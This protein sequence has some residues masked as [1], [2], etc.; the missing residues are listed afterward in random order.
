MIMR[1]P[2]LQ[3]HICIDCGSLLNQA[4]SNSRQPIFNSHY[5]FS[6]IFEHSLFL[7][8]VHINSTSDDG[9]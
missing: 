6:D 7:R 8:N 4:C 3:Q 9:A 5:V 1:K 2:S